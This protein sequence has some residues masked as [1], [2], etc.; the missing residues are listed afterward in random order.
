M[1]ITL[2]DD[3]VVFVFFG[4]RCLQKPTVLT[5]PLFLECSGVSIYSPLKANAA[6]I[7]LRFFHT[8]FFM[9]NWKHCILRHAFGLNYFAYFDSSITQYHIVDFF[10][11]FGDNKFHWTSRTRF[12]F[13]GCTATFKLI[14]P[15]V[16]T[17]AGMPWISSN[18]ALI[19]FD[20]KPFKYAFN[21]RLK[22]T[23]FHLSNHTKVVCF[24]RQ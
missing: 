23:F 14:Y 11:H 3:F 24:N 22:L 12:I 5:I 13:C 21:L 8:Q 10:N 15:F 7:L 2:P 20:F 9:Q 18:L 4:A 6:P 16:N 1:A 17:R 19:S